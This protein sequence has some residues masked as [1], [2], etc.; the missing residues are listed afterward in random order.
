MY[1]FHYDQIKNKY[2]GKGELLFIDAGSLMYEI[3]NICED[4]YK[5]KELFDFSRYSKKSS[6][7]DQTD[8]L[9]NMWWA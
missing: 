1:D 2:D 7:Y 8:N 5:S 3:K 6:Y 4:F 9:K